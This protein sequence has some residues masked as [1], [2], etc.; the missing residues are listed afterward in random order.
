MIRLIVIAFWIFV[1]S[2]LLNKLYR[3]V[4]KSAPPQSTRQDRL[5][6]VEMVQ[7]P[8]CKTY[9]PKTRAVTRRIKGQDFS[10]CSEACARQ[11]E[12]SQRT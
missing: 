12:Q 3:F 8:Q 10:F 4:V 2:L 5:K 1:I 7:D 6:G 11:Y 9:V